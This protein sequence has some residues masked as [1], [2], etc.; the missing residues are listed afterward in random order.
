[1]GATT[2]TSF[3]NEKPLNLVKENVQ[4]N[5]DEHPL[6]INEYQ[7]RTI[8]FERVFSI[9]C[10]DNFTPSALAG[11]EVSI[12]NSPVIRRVDELYTTNI[13]KYKVL[14]DIAFAEDFNT[15][16]IEKNRNE[17]LCV[18]PWYNASRAGFLIAAL[19]FGLAGPPGA[20]LG[21][22]VGSKIGYNACVNFHQNVST[23]GSTFRINWLQQIDTLEKLRMINIYEILTNRCR[24]LL[25]DLSDLQ[26]V[27]ESDIRLSTELNQITRVFNACFPDRFLQY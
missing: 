6:I 18:T 15:I 1:M 22:V 11:L 27:N 3:Y 7:K 9:L 24:A 2:I 16:S 17:I 26:S 8:D 4:L 13:S 23:A 5:W 19:G 12:I 25:R 20:A 21:A 14:R 10:G